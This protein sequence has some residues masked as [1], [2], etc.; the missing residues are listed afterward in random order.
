M[1]SD[2]LEALKEP[3]GPMSLI[4]YHV[5]AIGEAVAA[6][7][8]SR[9]PGFKAPKAAK[10]GRPKARAGLVSLGL[11]VITVRSAEE[12]DNWDEEVDEKMAE[13][14]GHP[15]S[16]SSAKSRARSLPPSSPAFPPTQPL[17]DSELAEEY[18][19]PDRLD[20]PSPP[21]PSSPSP[22]DASVTDDEVDFMPPSSQSRAQ[23][24]WLHKEEVD[25][26]ESSDPF[27]SR[28]D[29][30]TDGNLSRNKLSAGFGGG[31]DDAREGGCG[32]GSGGC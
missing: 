16:P 19:H 5:R 15:S 14:L 22:E 7:E 10:P 11:R 30:R 29:S 13:F 28:G 24:V 3:L 25:G 21:T 9:L 20:S 8:T 27:L 23:A 2:A 1:I 31:E 32:G 26:L 4:D 18:Q 12:R 6:E 17:G